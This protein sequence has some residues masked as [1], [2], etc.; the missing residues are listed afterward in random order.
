MIT[1]AEFKRGA[2]ILIDN[3]P[4]SI[5]DYSVQSPSARGAS[6]LYKTK[7]RHLITGNM[8]E[9]TFKAG[10]RFDE[11]DVEER[12]AQYLYES[13]GEYF[14]L[15]QESFEQFGLPTEKME[16]LIP[17]LA[18]EAIVK[19][20]LFNGEVVGVKLPQFLE[21]EVTEAEPGARGDTAT[22]KVLKNAK[23]STGASVKVPIYLE[24]G[25]RILVDTTTGEF[26]KRAKS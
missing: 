25:E 18:E 23:I 2:Q 26:V 14:F 15:D 4:F 12:E 6:T 11:P 17:F 22:G 10:D 24:V 19:S 9:K 3:E 21:F 5:V 13:G 7:V 20:V 8:F 1:T 16:D